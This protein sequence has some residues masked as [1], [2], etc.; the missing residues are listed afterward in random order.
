M[1]G[2]GQAAPRA[3]G[4]FEDIISRQISNNEIVHG[5][6]FLSPCVAVRL[7]KW[8]FS[9]ALGDTMSTFFCHLIMFQINLL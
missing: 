9:N 8:H 3:C 1:H 5:K 6:L 2:V 7:G 4:L